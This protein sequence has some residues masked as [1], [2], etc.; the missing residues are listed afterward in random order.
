MKIRDKISKLKAEFDKRAEHGSQDWLLVNLMAIEIERL[1]RAFDRY[2]RFVVNSFSFPDLNDEDAAFFEKIAARI[3]IDG[4]FGIN[5]DDLIYFSKM[6]VSELNRLSEI[7]SDLNAS[8]GDF[9]WIESK[10][11]EMIDSLIEKGER[12][13][14]KQ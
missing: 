8:T 11:Q 3:L 9:D 12:E 5:T 2:S 6:A 10:L 7:N 1:E 14:G 4:P 13:N